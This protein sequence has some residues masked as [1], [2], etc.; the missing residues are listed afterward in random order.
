MMRKRDAY[1]RSEP[2]NLPTPPPKLALAPST[3]T[4]RLQRSHGVARIAFKTVGRRTVLADL[5]QAGSAKVRLPR[6]VG[7]EAPNAVVLNTS[8]G[9]TD[10]DTFEVAADWGPATVAS[11]TTQAAERVY[12]ARESDAHV[13]NVLTVG[14]GATALWVPQE[15]I[16][17]DG[18]RLDRGLSVALADEAVFVGVEAVILGRTAMGE[19][20]RSGA[21]IDRWRVRRGGRLIYADGLRFAGDVAAD[22]GGPG[23]LAGGLAFATVVVARPDAAALL[24]PLRDAAAGQAARVGCSVR[25]DVLVVRV[26]GTDGLEMRRATV[27]LLETVHD[28]LG[29]A[30]ALP[31][32]WHL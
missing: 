10:G 8:G 4:G 28:T 1:G 32:V 31:R 15:T 27:A 14:A 21:M 2:V 24:A 25:D 17:F 16:V 6:V 26:V 20:V 3:E 7:D 5:H 23:T 22:L 29:A 18:G 12:R 19:T 30:A 9:L 13:R 11:V